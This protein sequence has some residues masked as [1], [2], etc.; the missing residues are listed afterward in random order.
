MHVKNIQLKGKYFAVGDE[1]E[2][3]HRGF[4][5]DKTQPNGLREIEIKWRE[6]TGWWERADGSE[7]GDLA[8]YYNDEG[9][10]EVNDF[11]GAYDLPKYLR[12]ELESLGVVINF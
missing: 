7:G 5:D 9:K 4:V 3:K 6:L 11:D 12:A 10:L 2:M 1:R 8:L